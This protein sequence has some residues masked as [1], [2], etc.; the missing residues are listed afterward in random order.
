MSKPDSSFRGQCAVVTGGAGLL[1]RALALTFAE[2]G[3]N[4]VVADLDDERAAIVAGEVC[5]LGR[6]AIAV[7]VDVA[8]RDSMAALADAA[9]AKFGAVNVLVNN[10]GVV[11][12]KKFEEY[13][14]DDWQRVLNVQMWGVINGVYAFLP[15]LLAQGGA[16]HIVNVSSMS[17]IGLAD[18]RQ[19]NAPYVTAKFAVAG[20]TEVM[21]PAL[22]DKGIDVSLLCPGFFVAD[23]QT[24]PDSAF[25]MP[26]AA[27]YKHNLLDG[28][29][30]A[31]EVL[32]GIAERRF[33]I[34]PHRAGRDEVEQRQRRILEG[35]DQAAR[36][37]PPLQKP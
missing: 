1:G 25:Q 12:L 13:T 8:D 21:A 27:W 3:M 6:E 33:Y 22:Q 10:A 2:A 37:S 16:R 5:A 26:S 9:Y 4:V 24:F 29:E 34:L 7:R 20:F 35:F 14:Y 18:M 31:S 17:G 36:T 15:R 28:F 30:V 11:I 19:L 32:R 23:P